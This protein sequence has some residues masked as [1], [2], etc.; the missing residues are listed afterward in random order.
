MAEVT[1]A[2]WPTLLDPVDDLAPATIITSLRKD[3]GKLLITGISH[4]NGTITSITVNGKAADRSP[5]I[6]G[7]VDWRIELSDTPASIVA[8]AT[9]EA[10]NVEQ[11]GHRL[12]VGVPLAKK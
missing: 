2:D 7:V 9:D 6:A 3:Q 11:T 8:I 12:T 1:N 5:Q 4:D 10:G